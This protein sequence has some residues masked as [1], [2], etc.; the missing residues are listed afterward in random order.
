MKTP[1][2]RHLTLPCAI[3]VAIFA[4]PRRVVAGE[5]I[6]AERTAPPRWRLEAAGT[7]AW[8]NDYGGRG[9]GVRVGESPA[10]VAQFGVAVDTVRLHTEGSFVSQDFVNNTSTTV[11]YSQTFRSTLIGAYAR[12][13]LPYEYATPYAE[14]VYGGVLVHYT[15]A[16]NTACGYGSGLAVSLSGGID[17]HPLPAL[18][19]GLRA[20]IRNTGWGG[21]CTVQGG[22]WQGSDAILLKSASMAA[23]VRW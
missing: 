9:I 12:F 8:A 7:I 17:L 22:V 21:A 20:G 16:T 15:E 11:R 18:A 13:Q 14:L 23:G 10:R 6:V 4:S 19:I 2:V 1:I 5:D 3:A